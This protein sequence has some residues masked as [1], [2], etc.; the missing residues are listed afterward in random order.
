MDLKKRIERLEKL[1]LSENKE[2]QLSNY[3]DALS[4]FLLDETPD[5]YARLK[6][7]ASNFKFGKRL[8]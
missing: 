2:K 7:K 4:D 6:E 3:F 5:N 1:T 8:E